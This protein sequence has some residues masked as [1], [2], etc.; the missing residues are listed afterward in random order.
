MPSVLAIDDDPGILKLIEKALSSRGYSVI[1]AHNGTEGMNRLQADRPDIV[2]LDKVMPDID[3]FEVARRLRREPGF[4][5]IPIVIL[6]GASQLGDKL[7]AF[8]AG[9]D[10]YL[11]KPFEID[12]LAARLAALLRRAEAFKAAQTQTL[13]TIDAARLIAVHSLRGGIG[14]SSMAV[15]LAYGFRALWRSPVLLM[16]MDLAYGQIALLLNESIKRTWSDL[17]TF[18]DATYDIEALESIMN[19]HGSGLQF[20]AAPKDPIDADDV[21]GDMLKK[22]VRLLMPRFEYI[23]AD[24]PHDFGVV[25]LDILESADY[26]VLMVAPEIVAIR[27]AS[28]A[29]NT[30]SELGFEKS[31]IK[32]VLN[33]TVTRTGL[34]A[35][36]I[37]EALNHPIT[38]VIPNQ[39]RAFLTAINSGIPLLQSHPEHVVSSLVE[40]FC[41]RLSKESHQLLPPPVP[42]PTWLRVNKRLKI[43]GDKQDQSRR[44][45]RFR[46]GRT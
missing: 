44:G 4:A 8:N 11:T 22:A 2:I 33:Q 46:L 23:V 29:L 19:K 10:D 26:I 15:N 9:A 31:K 1:T 27:A 24:I 13:D 38:M 21:G 36:Q 34:N 39:S 35:T 14:C 3:G 7:D 37:E 30:Y 5:H 40:D 6:T 16:D 41:F 32:L 25:S 45:L 28:V 12:E 42:S 18:E 20:I 43:S 17:A